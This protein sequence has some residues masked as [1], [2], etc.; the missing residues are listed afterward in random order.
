[1]WGLGQRIFL[2]HDGRD[3]S[4]PAAIQNHM[5]N[6]SEANTVIT[7]YNNLNPTQK[8]ELVDFLRSL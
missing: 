7:N 3:L 1:L 6:G 4:V 8:Q 2:L 5:S